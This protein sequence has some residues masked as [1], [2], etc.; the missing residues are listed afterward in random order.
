MK[1][2]LAILV[3]SALLGACA[4]AP[5]ARDVRE[6]SGVEMYEQLC[7]SCHGYGYRMQVRSVS[8]RAHASVRGAGAETPQRKLA[9]AET[10]RSEARPSPY[11]FFTF[12]IAP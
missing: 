6:L 12:A 2:P 5:D 10:M 9:S 1:T 8:A 11:G 4:A 3:L 7:A